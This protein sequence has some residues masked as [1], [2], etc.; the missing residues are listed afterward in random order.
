MTLIKGIMGGVM[1]ILGRELNFLFAGSMT[2]LLAIRFISYLPSE[3]TLLV[4]Y[5]I[6]RWDG[7]PC[8]SGCHAQ[9]TRRFRHF[10]VC[11]RRIHSLRILFPRNLGSTDPAFYCWKRSW[12]YH[13]GSTN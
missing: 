2:A 5:C 4:K 10:R 3:S 11:R 9:R 8:C 7:N 6:R 13:H 1:L 12:C